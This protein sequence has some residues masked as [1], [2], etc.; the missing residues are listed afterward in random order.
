MSGVRSLEWVVFTL[1][2]TFDA[3]GVTPSSLHLGHRAFVYLPAE[4]E[5]TLWGCVKMCFYS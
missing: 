3:S 2:P 5:L 1:K 4:L